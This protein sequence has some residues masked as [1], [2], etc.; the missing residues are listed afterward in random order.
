MRVPR[1]K[2]AIAVGAAAAV[3]LAGCAQSERDD[4]DDAS[5]DTD[6]TLIFGTAGEALTLD[7]TFA[8]DGETMRVSRQVFDTLIQVAPG[9]TDI[10]PALATEW[11]SD[12]SGTEW[13]F[14][15]RDDVQF[16]DGTDFNAEAVC[17]NFDRWHTLEGVAQEPSMSYYWQQMSGGF[18]ENEPD[19]SDLGD[20]VYE[21]CA[22]TDEHTAVINLTRVTSRFPSLLV[23]SPFAMHSPT[24][25]AEHDASNVTGSAGEP[26]WPPYSLEHP[27]GTGPFVFESWDRA[28]QEITLVRNEDYWGEPATIGRLIFKAIPDETG[29]RQALSAGE[30]HGYDLPSPADWDTLESEG[31]NLGVRETPVNLLYVAFTQNANE[32]LEDLRVR[33]AIAHALNRQGLV[34]ALMPEGAEVATQFQ[35]PNLEGWN[36]DV[37]TYD[38]DPERAIQLLEDAGY[39]EG[40]LELSF[41]WPT[42]VTRPYMP[43]PRSMIEL[44]QQDLEDVGIVVEPVSL[45]WSPEY[46]ADVQ[47]GEADLHFLGWTGDYP[48][49]YNF[50]GTWFSR[51]LPAWGYEYEELWDRMSDADQTVDDEERFAIYEE[52]NAMIMEFLPGVPVSHMP[53][54]LVFA[55]HV[56]GVEISPLAQERFAT[57]QIAE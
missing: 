39:S 27:T 30:I 13:T 1:L 2:A 19:R 38:Y 4:D 10:E 22:A 32:A 17:S 48:E 3:A 42:D 35:P 25:L 34:D 33:Q 49:A 8:S 26:N 52:L 14:T 50:I 15:L 54:G 5:V 21:S 16:H 55:D 51:A 9:T 18:A 20:P 45:P 11:E 57:A 56:S 44:F 12:E 28:T 46:L 43:S 23:L 31:M 47:A 24:A 29:R 37:P 36:P 41:Y 6:A 7:P 40:E 53:N